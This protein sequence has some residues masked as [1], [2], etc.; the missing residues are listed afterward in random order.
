LWSD[1][2]SRLSFCGSCVV[3]HDDPDYNLSVDQFL[4]ISAEAGNPGIR[5]WRLLAPEQV[6]RRL[7]GVFGRKYQGIDQVDAGSLSGW[8]LQRFRP[9][10]VLLAL[11]GLYYSYEH[12]FKGFG[13]NADWETETC[14]DC[15][16]FYL[17]DLKEYK[18]SS[19]LR[20]I[21][22]RIGLTDPR[23]IDPLGIHN[24]PERG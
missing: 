12:T 21:G 10:P 13:H 16:S 4:Q 18:G 22:W 24:P 9:D 11:D 23:I 20:S 7:P 3:F 2:E 19:Y 1:V 5:T 6:I 14:E 15:K 8:P 17:S